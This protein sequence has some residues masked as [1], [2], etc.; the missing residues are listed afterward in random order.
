MLSWKHFFIGDILLEVASAII[1]EFPKADSTH[2]NDFRKPLETFEE[3]CQKLSI[4]AAFRDP[5]MWVVGLFNKYTNN[6][7][8][9]LNQ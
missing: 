3:I 5:S 4:P 6:F 1:K 7:L 2:S 8:N 9:P